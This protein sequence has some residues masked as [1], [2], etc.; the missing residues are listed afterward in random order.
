MG[1]NNKAKDQ[2]GKTYVGAPYNFVPMKKTVPYPHAENL[3][4]HNSTD[5]DFYS[6]SIVYTV[7]AMS[8]ISVG[9]EEK[10]GVSYFYKNADGEYA[11]PGSSMRGLIRSNAQILSGSYIG[12]DIDDYSLLY[13]EFTTK[14]PLKDRYDV[15]LGAD[16]ISIGNRQVS[17]LKEVRAGYM[18]NEGGKYVIYGTEIDKTVAKGEMNYYVLSERYINEHL[19]SFEYLYTEEFGYPLQYRKETVFEP[20]DSKHTKI[21]LDKNPEKRKEVK[22]WKP[23]NIGGDINKNYR[24]FFSRI[25][26]KL[27]DETNRVCGITSPDD[28]DTMQK[29]F[30][31]GTGF[32][33]EKKA[34]YV[35]PAIDEENSFDVPERD[36][37]AYAIDLNKKESIL[38]G[39]G[40]GTYDYYA[41]PKPGEVR[42]VFYIESEGRKYFGYT[43][44]LRLFYDHTVKEGLKQ[45]KKE[46]DY[47]R[48]LF[49]YADE[50]DARKGR[51]SFEDVV[52]VHK[53]DA[54]ADEESVALDAEDTA[55]SGQV[56]SYVLAGPKPTSYLD[57]LI[58]NN[59]K[60]STYNDKDFGIRG[61]KQYWIKQEID[62]EEPNAK[63]IKSAST[64]ETL[65][66]GT[67]F[68][69]TLHFK[70]L[71]KEELGLLLWSLELE[72]GSLQNIGKGK[73]YGFGAV[74]IKIDSIKRFDKE[75]AYCSKELCLDPTCDITAQAADL[76]AG[77]K[78]Q[79][80]AADDSLDAFMIMKNNR[81]PGQQV[82]YMRLGDRDSVREYQERKKRNASLPSPQKIVK[83]A[84]KGNTTGQADH[85]GIG[86][87]TPDSQPSPSKVSGNL[88]RGFIRGIIK[89]ISGESRSGVIVADN[90]GEEF[91]FKKSDCKSRKIFDNLNKD[92][93]VMFKKDESGKPSNVQKLS[94]KYSSQ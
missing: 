71:R 2:G 32:M 31:C 70:N 87:N 75:K 91:H 64:F 73:P 56:R 11:I 59:T 50:K 80:T 48:A 67:I 43:P 10:D 29:G 39:K 30:L 81:L 90:G 68:R 40:A 62:Q 3:P 93:E 27:N 34:L 16:S 23:Q 18:K 58:Q 49:G 74:K 88:P 9:G 1:K 47:V 24:P 45:E 92:D 22:H 86:S 76:I 13:R 25:S 41:L 17:V 55:V 54:V 36:V 52:E 6:G 69:G 26:Y 61:V 85:Q 84:E 5:E 79:K 21:D 14:G 7:T 66:A 38:K 42:P 20:Y 12:D 60:A 4:A 83:G 53:G 19:S 78:A 94:K 33:N 77:Y 57:Y 44:R 65:P 72:G 28:V 46:L 89:E 82:R 15:V 35:I 63:G 37:R 51:V 8:E